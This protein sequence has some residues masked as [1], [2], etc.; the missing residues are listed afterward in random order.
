MWRFE[1]RTSSDRAVLPFPLSPFP[2]WTGVIIRYHGPVPIIDDEALVLDHH[3]FRDRDL[4]LAVIC[5]HHGVQRGILRRARSGKAPAAAAAQI[6]SHV[7]VSLFQ[8][9]TAE[10]ATYRHIELIRSSFGLTTQLERSAAGAVVAELLL[11]YFPPSESSERAFRLGLKS[12]EALL[13]NTASDTVVA[14]AQYWTLALG[15]VLGPPEAGSSPLDHA[16]LE[17]LSQCRR[18]GVAEI[19]DPVPAA[20][21]RWLDQRAREE[22]E[23]PLRALTFYR[24]ECG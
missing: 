8:K 2:R 5:R 21:A 18:R 1:H 9:P 20:A 23:R 19:E 16:S 13:E 24:R 17:F 10:L 22:A 3:R 12:L 15:G 6:L 4:V 14:Y 11:T 7:H